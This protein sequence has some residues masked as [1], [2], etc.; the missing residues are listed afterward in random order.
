MKYA[1]TGPR[2][3]IFN[4]VDVEPTGGQNYS[5]ISDADAAIVEA[6]EDRFFIVDG[7]LMTMDEFRAAKQQE[8][9]E[10]QVAEF[11]A[12]VEGAKNFCKNRF[13]EKREEVEK[14]GINVG[15]IPVRTD[16]VTQDKLFQARFISNEVK[17]PVF[18][19]MWKLGNGSFVELDTPTIIALSNGVIQHLKDGYTREKDLSDLIDAATTL[20]ELQAITW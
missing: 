4:I 13:S 10:A 7:V 14:G 15:G 19:T 16:K 1:I 20:A 3:A 12:D 5:E 9:F 8:R 2:G 18:T 6:S 17:P 11:G